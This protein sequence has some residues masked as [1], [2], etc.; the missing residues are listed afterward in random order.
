MNRENIVVKGLTI[1]ILMGTQV[2]A[3]VINGFDDAHYSDNYEKVKAQTEK[4][5][6]KVDKDVINLRKT[7]E[8]ERVKMKDKQQQIKVRLEDLVDRTKETNRK[9]KFI[10][11]T[12]QLNEHGLMNCYSKRKNMEESLHK[13]KA[14]LL[15]N[16]ENSPKEVEELYNKQFQKMQNTFDTCLDNNAYERTKLADIK[17][18]LKKIK[19]DIDFADDNIDSLETEQKNIITDLQLI[20]SKLKLI[21]D[22]KYDKLK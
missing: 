11:A 5:Q 8:A 17:K 3:K 13:R 14:K 4:E 19:H 20:Q 18:D 2:D 22:G 16:D 9:L 10:I 6:K 7:T 1:L 12:L 21:E 15:S